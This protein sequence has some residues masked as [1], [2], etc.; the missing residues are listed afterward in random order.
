[1]DVSLDIYKLVHIK[2]P[3]PDFVPAGI[4]VY[5]CEQQMINNPFSGNFQDISAAMNMARRV[6]H[7]DF[8]LSAKA[9]IASSL[10]YK[11]EDMGDWDPTT[12]FVRL[13]QAEIVSG[14]S[15]DPV[16]PKAIQANIKKAPNKREFTPVQQKAIERIKERNRNGD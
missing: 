7:G 10:H 13:A 5:I 2:G 8:L 1:M 6:V 14:R 12:F 16:D 3:D 15:F 4:P 11:I 9:M